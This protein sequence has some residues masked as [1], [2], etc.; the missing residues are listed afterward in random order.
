[1]LE[2]AGSLALVLDTEGLESCRDLEPVLAAI[3]AA[4]E[5]R[6]RVSAWEEARESVL[7]VLD[8]VMA[9]IHREERGFIPLA[10]CQE[11]AREMQQ[12]CP[13]RRQT[14]SSARPDGPRPNNMRNQ[15]RGNKGI[16]RTLVPASNVIVLPS[17]LPST[18]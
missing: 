9:L 1:M 18:E 15:P 7:V 3:Q 8:R 12:P 6:A 5:H 10:Q 16:T 11:R 14:I 17:R 2:H 13:G 4:E